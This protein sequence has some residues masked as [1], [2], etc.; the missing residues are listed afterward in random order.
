VDQQERPE[1]QADETVAE[2]LKSIGGGEH[3]IDQ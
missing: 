1:E 3:L 2:K